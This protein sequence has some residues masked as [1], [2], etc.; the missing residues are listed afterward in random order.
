MIEL[1]LRA[2]SRDEGEEQAHDGVRADTMPLCHL[3]N[4]LASLSCKLL[5]TVLARVSKR[6][7]FC[8][9]TE[10]RSGLFGNTVA[11]R[12]QLNRRNIPYF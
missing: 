9:G 12:V 1:R 3:I 2:L 11:H 7:S 4:D 10:A 6:G 5:H 8:Q